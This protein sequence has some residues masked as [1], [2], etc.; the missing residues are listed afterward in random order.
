MGK[1]LDSEEINSYNGFPI[2]G[3]LIKLQL[4]WIRGIHDYVEVVKMLQNCPKLQALT[5]EKVCH[6]NDSY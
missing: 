4:C 1:I 5:I 3:N 2:F 6:I